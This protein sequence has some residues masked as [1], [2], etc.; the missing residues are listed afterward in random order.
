[1]TTP[2]SSRS[3][4]RRQLAAVIATTLAVWGVALVLETSEPPSGGAR[5]LGVQQKAQPPLIEAGCDVDGVRVDYGAGFRTSPGTPEYKIITADVSEVAPTC[6]GATV[7]VRMLGGSSTLATATA[8]ASA[9][10]VTLSFPTP[11]S[12]KQVNGVAVEIT[13]GAVPVPTECA[14]MTFDRFVVLTAG[15]DAHAGSKD[16]DLTYGGTGNDTLRGDNQQDCL[17]GQAGNDQL[18]GDNHDDVLI[19]GADND[20]LTGGSGDDKLH[21]GPGTDRCVGGPGK[22]TFTGCEIIQ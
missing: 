9:T 19:G 17:D 15:N 11:P 8:I 2:P 16:R 20:V 18:F 12:A 13:G 5:V 22:N 1:V 7:S 3:R 4:W 6:A 10:T 21:G 14:A